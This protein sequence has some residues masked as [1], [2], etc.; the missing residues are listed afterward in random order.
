MRTRGKITHWNGEKGYGF[1]T[2]ES[3]AKQVFVHISAL[4]NRAVPPPPART[5][6]RECDYVK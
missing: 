4:R 2:P 5:F 1:I 6:S 3:G